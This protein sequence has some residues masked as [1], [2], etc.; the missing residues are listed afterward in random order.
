MFS[1]RFYVKVQIQF[2]IFG[3]QNRAYAASQLVDLHQKLAKAAG[4]VPHTKPVPPTTKD[5]V[6]LTA[7]KVCLNLYATPYII[8]S[9]SYRGARRRKTR[10]SSQKMSQT[11]VLPDEGI[12]Q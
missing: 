9:S 4:N 5:E 1:R 7:S 6:L 11:G 2:L 8:S 3:T 10:I 12:Y